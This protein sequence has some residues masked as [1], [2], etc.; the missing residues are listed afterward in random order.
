MGFGFNP[1]PQISH[2]HQYSTITSFNAG[3][4]HRLSGTTGPTIRTRFSH[5][6]F[7]Q[8]TTT[9][10][11]GHVHFYRNYTGPAIPTGPNTHVHRFFGVTTVNGRFPHVHRYSGITAPARNDVYE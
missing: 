8:G 10:N 11:D 9:F 7:M 1:S 6:H 5:I 2:V 3:H 4:T